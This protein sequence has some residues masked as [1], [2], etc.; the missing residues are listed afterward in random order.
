MPIRSACLAP[1]LTAALLL[2]LSATMNSAA[3]GPCDEQIAQTLRELSVP[4]EDVKSIDLARRGKGGKSSSNY[5]Q[6]AIVRLNSCSGTLVINMT[7]YCMVQ[8][9]YTT[10]DCSVGG[11]PNY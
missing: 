6:D 7:R 3:A 8:Q 4:Q 2:S 11:M 1:G 10:G 9:S 5:T